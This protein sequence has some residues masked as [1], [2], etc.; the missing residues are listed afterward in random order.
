MPPTRHII[1][2]YTSS[3]RPSMISDY[4]A[5]SYIYQGNNYEDNHAVEGSIQRSQAGS[6]TNHMQHS[7]T[8]AQ[9]YPDLSKCQKRL[10]LDG[11]LCGSPSEMWTGI[12]IFHQNAIEFPR[13]SRNEANIMLDGHYVKG[14]HHYIPPIL[15]S[16][17]D[18]RDGRASGNITPHSERASTSSDNR[19]HSPL[20]RSST[21]ELPSAGWR[22]I[23]IS[24]SDKQIRP[25]SRSDAASIEP[26]TYQL[27]DDTSNG[28]DIERQTSQDTEKLCDRCEEKLATYRNE[29][30]YE[31]CNDCELYC[32]RWDTSKCLTWR[33]PGAHVRNYHTTG[34]CKYY[35][36]KT[37]PYCAIHKGSYLQQT[38]PLSSLYMKVGRG[39]SVLWY[40]GR[41]EGRLHPDTGMIVDIGMITETGN[42]ESV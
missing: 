20:K 37:K 4:N 19:H 15:P 8:S 22:S 21:A 2:P 26:D 1:N 41:P 23:S 30:G 38:N 14:S 29:N 25:L 36:H 13:R 5:R 12:C 17:T 31:W 35:Q 16:N 34:Q 32:R 7:G 24:T 39:D 10:Q 42:R 6:Y 27:S 33:T 28:P 3:P 18:H 40:P 9:D 11:S